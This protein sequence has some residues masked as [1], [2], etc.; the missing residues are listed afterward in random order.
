MTDHTDDAEALFRD[1]ARRHSFAIEK[2]DGAP[3]ELLMRVPSQ[4]GLSFELAL[5]LQN[6]DEANIGFA[7]FW[8]YFFPYENKRQIVSDAL[9][10]LATGDCRLAVHTQLGGVV[11]RVL[12][13]RS[14]GTWQTI[15]TAFER[16]QIPLLKTKISYVRNEE[17]P[18]F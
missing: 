13:V 15:Y 3:V 4:P 1:F 12:E 6:G 7:E 8:S 10:G 2:L 9:D 11:K 16:I 5:G 18:A 17:A 14:N